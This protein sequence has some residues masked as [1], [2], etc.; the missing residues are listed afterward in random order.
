MSDQHSTEKRKSEHIDIAL[1]KQVSG[2]GITTGFENFRFIHQA[3]PEINFKDI[4]IS[5]TFLNKR[6]KAPLVLSSMTGGTERA[7]EINLHLASAAEKRGWAVGTGSVRAALE[8]PELGFTYN[9]RKAAP[10]IPIFTNLGAVQLNA[11]YGVDECRRA[12]DIVQADALVLHLNSMQEVFQTEGDTDFTGLLKKIESVC[13]TLEVPVGIKEVGMGING[14]LA[15]QLF[16]AGAS[17][18]DVAGAGGTSWIQVEKF[19]SKDPVRIQ[20]AEA[21]YDWG[22]PTSD[23]I[24]DVRKAIPD[25]Q[26]TLVASGGLYTGVDAAKAIAIGADLAG[27]GR[28][29]LKDAVESEEALDKTLERIEMELKMAMFGIGAHNLEELKLSPLIKKID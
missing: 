10:S 14:Q 11:G 1:N 22:I 21:F 20:A 27:F 16:D 3:L 4:D 28:S 25:N 17:F 8:N 13:T 29:I 24:V 23:C 7:W 19:R 15:K 26:K 2:R 9:M 12:V 18:V 5:T 6:I